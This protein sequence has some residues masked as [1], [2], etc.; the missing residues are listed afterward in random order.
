MLRKRVWMNACNAVAPLAERERKR[1]HARIEK[2]DL[3]LAIGDGFRL[4]DQLIQPLFGNRAV[5]L[6]VHVDAVG[7]ARRPSVDKHAKAHERSSRRRPHHEMEIA[8]VKAARD[9]PTGLVQDSGLFLHGPITRK[10]P[11]IRPEPR[12]GSID[13][14]LSHSCAT[15][16]AKIL[17]PLIA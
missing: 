10:G 8:G 17:G 4:S 12:G 9:A 5:A 16:G 3:E 1:F 6:V 15:G 11:L 14:T 2:L 13:T 7:S